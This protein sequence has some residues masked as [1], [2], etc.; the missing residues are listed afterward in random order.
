MFK[1]T[2]G[3]S[4]EVYFIDMHLY[5]K[6]LPGHTILQINNIRNGRMNAVSY[7]ERACIITQNDMALVLLAVQKCGEKNHFNK[8]KT[9]KQNHIIMYGRFS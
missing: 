4:C 8:N 5:F 2:I 1:E 7:Y 9:K 3:F 6:I